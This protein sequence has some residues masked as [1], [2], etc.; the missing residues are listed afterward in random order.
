MLQSVGMTA[1]Q[2]K[3]MLVLESIYY[4][5]LALL[6]FV[7]AG[8]AVSY[9]AVNTVTQGSAAYTYKFSVVPLMICFPVLLLL[10]CVLPIRVYKSISRDSVVQRLRE[11]E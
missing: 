8:Y 10:A 9:F 2:G 4:M 3:K 1:K 7:T 5:A 6:V 11:N